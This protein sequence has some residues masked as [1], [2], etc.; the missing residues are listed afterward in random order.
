MAT[1][2]T[3][4]HRAGRRDYVDERSGRGDGLRFGIARL[5][6][7]VAAIVAGII[8]LGILLVVLGASRSNDLV[9][10]AL[11]AARWLAG[12]FDGLFSLS[13]RKLE[14]GVNWGI[15]AAVYLLVGRLIARVIG[16]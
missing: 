14:T 9:G 10:V 6:G 8:V 13:G 3:M 2:S 12:P 16:R 4:R 15:A 5:V 7:T 1:Y 11:D